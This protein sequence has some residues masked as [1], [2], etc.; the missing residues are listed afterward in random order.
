MSHSESQTPDRWFNAYDLQQRQQL[1]RLHELT[2]YTRWALVSALWLTVVPF[3]LWEL[4]ADIALWQVYF[5]WAAV[6]YA[7]L[8]NPVAALGLTLTVALTLST[9]MW[10][11]RN[12]LLGLPTAEIHRLERQLQRIHRQGVSHPLW[13]WVSG[14]SRP[15][16]DLS[17]SDRPSPPSDQ[18]V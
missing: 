10:Q 11:S 13:R 1:T 15:Q 9:L 12:I 7:L 4:R 16:P 2:V 5:T 6:R 17:A 14:A 3:S 8:Y 18:D